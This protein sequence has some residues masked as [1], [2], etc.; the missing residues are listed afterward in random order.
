MEFGR[1]DHLGE[2]LH[3]SWLDI[4]DVEALVLYVEVP[5]IDSQIVTADKGLSVAVDGDTVDV[6][7][8]CICVV[9]A[10]D[11]SDNGIMMCKARKFER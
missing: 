1:G 7:S 10:W 11:R 9:S 8:V 3:I 4:D 6:V 2:L 5:Q